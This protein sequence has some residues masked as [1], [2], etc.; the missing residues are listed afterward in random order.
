VSVGVSGSDAKSVRYFPARA[1]LRHVHPTVCFAHKRCFCPFP[2]YA[3]DSFCYPGGCMCQRTEG[4]TL[5]EQL[6]RGRSGAGARL[7]YRNVQ[8]QVVC[9]ESGRSG[10]AFTALLRQ[11]LPRLRAPRQRN[12]EYEKSLMYPSFFSCQFQIRANNWSWSRREPTGHPRLVILG[13]RR[14]RA[15]WPSGP[16]PPV[17]RLAPLP[18]R[19]PSWQSDRQRFPRRRLALAP[20]A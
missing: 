20:A 16:P 6:Y 17:H 4:P 2:R 9:V 8:I 18:A 12:I 7:I 19:C 10:Q 13:V 1:V 5:L 11:R 3:A 15:Y 14:P